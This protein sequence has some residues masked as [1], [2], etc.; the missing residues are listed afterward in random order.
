MRAI[1]Y[2]FDENGTTVIEHAIVVCIMALV[3][4]CAVGSG[5]SPGE[6]LRRIEILSDAVFTSEPEAQTSDPR[7][8]PSESN[9]MTL[10][11]NTP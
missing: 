10:E 5:L 1:E 6:A 2:W 9:G 7:A 4:V 11:Q 3:I 8:I